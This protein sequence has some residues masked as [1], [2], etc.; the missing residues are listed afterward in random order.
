[1]A[2]DLNYMA[3]SEEDVAVNYRNAA[4]AVRAEV[5]KMIPN[6]ETED[7]WLFSDICTAIYHSFIDGN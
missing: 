6:I 7:F 4:N 1:M 2:D 5:R 3:D